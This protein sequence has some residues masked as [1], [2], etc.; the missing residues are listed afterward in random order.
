MSYCK[1]EVEGV[2]DGDVIALR[3]RAEAVDSLHRADGG[4]VERG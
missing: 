4:V 3:K 1:L 2:L